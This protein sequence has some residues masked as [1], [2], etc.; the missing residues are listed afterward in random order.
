MTTDQ[1]YDKIILSCKKIFINKASDYGTAWR[2]LRT[3]SIVDQIFIKAQR[4]RTIQEKKDQRIGD[5]IASEFKGI[6]NYAV[7]G[8]IQLELPAGSPEELPVDRVSALYDSHISIAKKLMQDKNH[9]YGEAWRSMSQESFV[10]LI[11]MKLQRIRQILINEGKTLISEGIDANYLDILNYA[12][13]ALI[14]LSESK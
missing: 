4:I 6:I 2:V 3:I 5:D 14:L 7:I 11:L 8:S 1:Q 9:D 13:F 10:D 12:V